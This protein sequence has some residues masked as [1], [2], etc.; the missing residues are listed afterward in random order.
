MKSDL[1]NRVDGPEDVGDV[2]YG[3]EAGLGPEQ[4][5]EVLEVEALRR[6][7]SHEPK[8]RPAPLREHLGAAAQGGGDAFGDSCFPGNLFWISFLFS[9]FPMGSDVIVVKNIQLRA[10]ANTR[11][12]SNLPG[13][14]VAVVLSH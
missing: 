2:P 5:P 10:C 13:H 9:F 1:V 14:K 7:E 3:D 8:H 4:L 12:S 6:V 11:R